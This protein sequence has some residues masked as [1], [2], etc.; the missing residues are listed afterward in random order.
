MKENFKE[1]SFYIYKLLNECLPIYSLFLILF[2]EKGLSVVEISLLLSFWSLVALLSEVPSGIIA[3]RWNRKYMLFIATVLKAICFAI[4]F[5]SNSFSMFA[6]G[7]L[8]GGISVSFTSGTEEG[9]IYD[10]LKSEKREND[11]S[12]IYGKGRFYSSIGIIIG[13][14]SGGVLANFISIST[15]FLMSV[16]ILTINL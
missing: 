5:I 13:V 11:F 16:A 1:K 10:N 7:F 14:I 15:I 6:L 2:I 4:W 12:K 8:F 9:L 3:D